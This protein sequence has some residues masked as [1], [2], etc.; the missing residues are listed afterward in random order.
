MH[1]AAI[2]GK[3]SMRT[4]VSKGAQTEL[5]IVDVAPLAA[6]V[7]QVVIDVRAIGVG[8]VDLIMRQVVPTAF[9]P[10]IEA[11]G[12]VA[13]VGPG[14]D[15]KWIGRRVFALVQAGAYAEQVVAS[16][17]TLVTVP[18]GMTFEAAVASGVNA[19]VAHFC[20]AKANVTA[21]ETVLVRGAHGGIG[22]LA[23]QM[24]KGLGAQVTESF[25]DSIPASA[26]VVIDL[27]AGPD[28]GAYLEQLN[29]NGRYV[30]AGIAAGMPPADLASSLFADFRRS[31]SLIT[32][33]L[34]TVAADVLNRAADQIFR[35]VA[36]GSITPAIAET[37]T[38]EQ[39]NAAHRLLETGGVFG[40]I[41]MVP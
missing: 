7:G 14:V 36:T 1:H 16:S 34:D 38:I 39:S 32:Q 26:D 40:K 41:V 22:H 17:T 4:I 35:D 5:E 28:T 3:A 15:P 13:A 23:V 37:L 31:R 21:G 9:V 11:A 25:A 10:G 29:A 24:A 20:I 27:V 12:I 33:S 30:I 18:D 8:R 19:L 2:K 6:N